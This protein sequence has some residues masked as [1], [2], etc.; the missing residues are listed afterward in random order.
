MTYDEIIQE[1]G[2]RIEKNVYYIKNNTRYEVNIDNIESVK[3]SFNAP[4]LGSLMQGAEL[5]LKE[6]IEGT[7][8]IKIKASYNSYSASKTYGPYFLKKEPTFQADSKTYL[9]V[10]YDAMIKS[11]IP[12]EAVTITYPC[13]ILNF[14]KKVVQ[15]CNYTTTINSLPNGSLQMQSDIYTNINYTYRDV[16]ND[17]AIANG[18][19]IY[20][21]GSQIKISQINNN[22]TITIDDDILKNQNID[23][24]Q[25]FGPINTIV[26]SR[27][28]SDNIETHDSASVSQY[29]IHEYK[30]SDNQMMNDNNRSDFL[31]ALLTQLDGIEYDIYD[32]EL[33]G[34]GDI[35]PLQRVHFET[36]D[37]DYYS[38]V[39]NNEI[40]ITDGYKQTIFSEMPE[41]TNTD[42][43]MTDKTDKRMNETILIVDK[44]KQQI[45][46]KVSRDN[47]IAELN[48]AIED[49]N[50]GVIRATGNKFILEADNAKIDEFGNTE[51]NNSTLR[52][53]K[54]LLKDDGTQEGASIKI[55]T[56]SLYLK[57]IT[58]N[59][60][61]NSQKIKFLF[62][63]ITFQDLSSIHGVSSFVN[64]IQTSNYSLRLFK[65]VDSE[66]NNNEI[67]ALFQ[68]NT[69]KEKY[70]QINE[71]DEI[72]I[73]KDSPTLPANFGTITNIINNQ[74]MN[75]IKYINYEAIRYNT[76]NGHGMEA[77]IFSDY[78]FTLTDSTTVYNIIYGGV[79]PT[80]EQIEKYDINEN[81]IIDTDDY[82]T[83]SKWIN[84]GVSLQNPGKLIID[85]SV[86]DENIKLIDGN[87]RTAFSA[88]LDGVLKINDR[89]AS[90]WFGGGDYNDILW[91]ATAEG[92]SPLW[93]IADQEIEIDEN[94]GYLPHGILLIWQGFNPTTSALINTIVKTTYIPKWQFYKGIQAVVENM[95]FV[96][97][98]AL[99]TK[100]FYVQTISN[101]IYISGNNYNSSYG[102]ENGVTYD[103]RKFVLTAVL[104]V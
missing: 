68:G 20:A 34:Y 72:L 73:Y 62:D 86:P 82:S 89:F 29:G 22:N 61:L 92:N 79:I 85:S 67:V 66:Q 11:M 2:K 16:L 23:F 88:G 63:N 65:G 81:G 56:E 50:Q 54:L 28:V 32:T 91:D 4:L 18:I 14:F 45:Q 96:N 101:K 43:T 42:Y 74:I 93:M 76:V 25:H 97:Y 52:G 37:N 40:F 36:N 27:A 87:G 30:I 7:I 70:F 51:F 55:E 31:P 13:T 26:L 46:A 90:S 49:D 35:K 78:D 84:A 80:D 21:D 83:I 24:G 75:N 53:G 99:G 3:L 19:L 10:L 33:I 103:N 9:H 94:V 41:E 98:Q 12:Y 71:N 8:Y 57:T 60:N 5:V 17:I 64:L 44:Q 77:D 6:A 48:L 104:A 1:T 39:F 59:T 58:T 95:C 47:M 38:Y 100:L 15:A 102:T 69:L